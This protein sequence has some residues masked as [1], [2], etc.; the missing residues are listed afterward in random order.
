MG[1]KPIRYCRHLEERLALRGI[2][3]ELPERFIRGAEQVFD[4]CETGYRVAIGRASYGG[5]AEHLMMVA[6]EEL[7]NETVVITIHPL[8]E[9][10]VKAK[11]RSGRWR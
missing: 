6:F 4:D 2:D 7:V 5:T 10:D 3:R 1:D 11:L 9:R 8:E